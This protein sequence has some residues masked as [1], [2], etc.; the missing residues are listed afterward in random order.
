[1]E[2]H[3]NNDN[4]VTLMTI[5]S[6]KGLEF[7]N[8]FIIGMEEGIFPH[9]NSSDSREDLEEER[10]LC[11]VAITRAKKNLYLVNAKKRMIFGE[12]SYNMP[13]RFINEIDQ[14]CLN[15]ESKV[16][17]KFDKTSMISD[18]IDYSVGDKVEHDTYGI[19]IIVSMDK[20]IVTIAFPHPIGIKK[21]IKG[22]KSIRKV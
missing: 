4:V 11:Y 10:R 9:K 20:S 3:K 6:A 15:I 19:G 16:E 1:M 7:E 17:E 22:H 8:V 14:N 13:S 5:H 12:T 18:T 2:E 21:M